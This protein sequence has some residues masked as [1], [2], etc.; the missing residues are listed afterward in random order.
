M[1][2]GRPR[3][4]PRY[5]ACPALYPVSVRRVRALAIGSLQTPPR[6]GRPDLASR[7]RSSRSAENFHLQDSKHAWQTKKAT[8]PIRAVAVEFNLTPI[9]TVVA[10]PV[11]AV[12]T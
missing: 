10:L 7:F 11:I 5:P 6:G 9:Y 3:P 4:L 12:A 8:A 2:I 1:R